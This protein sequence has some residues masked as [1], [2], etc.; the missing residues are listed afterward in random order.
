VP[1]IGAVGNEEEHRSNLASI[2]AA[3]HT[4]LADHAPAGSG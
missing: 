4:E 1:N 2:V 3:H